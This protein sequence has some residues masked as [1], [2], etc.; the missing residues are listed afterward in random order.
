MEPR[1]I[2]E[3][4]CQTNFCKS[5]HVRSDSPP[6]LKH[7]PPDQLLHL[8]SFLHAH[9]LT[10]DGLEQTPIQEGAAAREGLRVI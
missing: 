7:F 1:W 5:N 2:P 6:S 4:L 8:T 10:S 9:T 3:N